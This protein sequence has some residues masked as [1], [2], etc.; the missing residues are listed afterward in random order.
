MPKLMK[1]QNG[2]FL[3]TIPKGVFYALN[4]KNGVIDFKINLKRG[5]V[6]LVR[7]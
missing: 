5:L 7:E 1:Q 2:Q 3:L 6:E 4:V